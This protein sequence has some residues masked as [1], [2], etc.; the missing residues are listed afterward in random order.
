MKLI[1]IRHG[2]P[3]YSIDSLTEKGFREAR[4]LAERTAKWNVTDFYCSPLGRARDTAAPTLEQT[5]RE[6][7]TQT[8]NDCFLQ[9]PGIGAVAVAFADI[10]I[11][12]EEVIQFLTDPPVFCANISLC[13]YR[14]FLPVAKVKQFRVRRHKF[15]I[16]I[17]WYFAARHHFIPDGSVKFPQPF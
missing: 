5:G 4:L 6:A 15:R 9:G 10:S 13:H 7:A 3:D 17:P 8:D 2:E 16:E 11:L 14:I 1:F 12:G